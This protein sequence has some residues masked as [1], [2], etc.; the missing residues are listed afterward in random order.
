[1]NDDHDYIPG[2][3]FLVPLE[4]FDTDIPSPYGKTT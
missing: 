4:D 3:G 1:M 2:N